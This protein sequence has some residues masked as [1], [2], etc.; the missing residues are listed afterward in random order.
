MPVIMTVFS[1]FE[2][3]QSQSSKFS[4]FSI[5]Q[6]KDNFYFD[7]EISFS[8]QYFILNPYP[9]HGVDNY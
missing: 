5:S 3:I 6:G 4:Q 9:I 2:S 8:G 1:Y 7:N